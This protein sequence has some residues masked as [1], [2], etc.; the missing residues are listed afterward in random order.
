MYKVS[1]FKISNCSFLGQSSLTAGGAINFFEYFSGTYD[2]ELDRERLVS[3]I[4][5]STFEDCQSAKGGAIYFAP[6]FS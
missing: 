3:Y 1:Q 5:D 4:K 2:R 6:L